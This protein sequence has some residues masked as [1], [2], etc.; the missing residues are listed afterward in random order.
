MA[1]AGNKCRSCGAT[2]SI[3]ERYCPKCGKEIL[4]RRLTKDFSGVL[5]QQG[6]VVIDDDWSEESQL[7]SKSERVASVRCESCGSI[8]TVSSKQCNHCGASL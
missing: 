5:H 6:R 7:H 3:K 1:K 2:V 4:Q 8:N